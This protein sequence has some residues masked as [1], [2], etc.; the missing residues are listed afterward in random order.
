MP[1]SNLLANAFVSYLRLFHIGLFHIPLSALLTVSPGLPSWLAS[2]SAKRRHRQ[3]SEARGERELG[4]PI[5]SLQGLALHLFQG[6][7]LP[8]DPTSAPFFLGSD[9]SISSTYLF[10]P[11][12]GICFL[13]YVS[14]WVPQPMI[15]SLTLA[16]PL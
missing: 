12:G 2:G 14:L 8:G 1:S 11:S 4:I 10:K 16:S 13:L 15:D 7:L 6:L 3:V 5:T 9:N